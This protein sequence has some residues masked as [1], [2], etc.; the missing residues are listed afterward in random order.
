MKD[1]LKAFFD[2]PVSWTVFGTLIA[3]FVGEPWT[4]V[5]R[6]IGQA[7]QAAI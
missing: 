3:A 4:T 7:V 5:V 2:N 6:F 1:K